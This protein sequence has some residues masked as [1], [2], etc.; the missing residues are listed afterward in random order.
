MN[1]YTFQDK[2]RKRVLRTYHF[3]EILLTFFAK[4]L[5]QGNSHQFYLVSF[6]DSGISCFFP[7]IQNGNNLSVKL[8]K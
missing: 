2:W 3:L 6:P 5:A 7:L 4:E 1:V 8:L